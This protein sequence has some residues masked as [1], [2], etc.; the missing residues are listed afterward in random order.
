MCEAFLKH[1]QK[2][3]DGTLGKS[4]IFAVNQQH[5][6]NLTKIL[7]EITPESA[8]TITSRVKDASDL[9]KDFRDGRR[10]EPIAVSVDMLSTGYNCRDL[11]NVVLMRPIFSPTEYIQ[12]K[13]RGTRLYTFKINNKKY[14]KE[15]FFLLDFCA[16]AE[17]FEEKYDYSLPLP[18]PK[19]KAEPSSTRSKQTARQAGTT[20]SGTEPPSGEPNEKQARSIPV[21]AGQDIVVSEE[22]KI[23]G[24]NGEKV[25]VMTFRG[26]FERDVKEFMQNDQEMK[27]AVQEEDDDAVESLLQERFLHK[28]EMYYSVD[29]LVLSYGVPAPTSAFVYNAVGK[30]PLPTKEVVVTDTVD[31]LA[32]RFNLRYHD[33][34]WVSATVNLIAD[35]PTALKKFMEGDISMFKSSQFN[36][37]GG[38]SALARFTE[39][40][41]VFEALRQSTLVRQSKLGANAQ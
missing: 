28:P 41:A 39:R 7:N 33:Q 2:K 30:K 34:K 29:K 31:S 23:V 37:L 40:D 8:V 21:W 36:Q 11:L 35:D 25:D 20:A 4:I 32:A 12:V 19:P 5:A 22:I 16:V 38:L 1:A 13:G 26:S 14:E 15:Y 9:A 17:Y 27:Q 3:P 18:I 10:K 24:P 6:T